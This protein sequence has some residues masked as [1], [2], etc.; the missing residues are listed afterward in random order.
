MTE[1]QYLTRK[2][3]SDY[4]KSKGIPCSPKTLAKYATIG[5]SPE[6][7]LF[8]NRRVVYEA[9]ALDR[10]IENKLSKPVT[11]TNQLIN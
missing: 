5:G 8:G 9:E 1:K 7:R 2:E 4:I 11:S 10:W 3:A 6:Y